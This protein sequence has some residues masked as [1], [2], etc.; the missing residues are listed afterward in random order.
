MSCNYCTEKSS[1]K[2]VIKIGGK[3]YS[4]IGDGWGFHCKTYIVADQDGLFR[5]YKD[6]IVTQAIEYCP[7]C[8]QRLDD[9]GGQK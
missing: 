7:K 4:A 6:G 1:N 2:T 3:E 9:R 8:G 5:I